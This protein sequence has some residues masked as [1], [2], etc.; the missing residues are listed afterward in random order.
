LLPV[1]ISMLGFGIFA[2]VMVHFVAE[3][4]PT[5]IASELRE[6]TARQASK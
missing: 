1:T 3:A 4:K 6:Q 2:N 5:D